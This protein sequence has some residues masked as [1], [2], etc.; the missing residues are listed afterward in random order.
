MKKFSIKNGSKTRDDSRAGPVRH[1]GRHPH[2]CTALH[3]M[4]NPDRT[5]TPSQQVVTRFSIL[6][7]RL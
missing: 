7:V 6:A 1:S 5:R 4:T 3:H 2:N